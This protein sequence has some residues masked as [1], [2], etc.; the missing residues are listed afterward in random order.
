M[1]ASGIHPYLRRFILCVVKPNTNTSTWLLLYNAP[2]I[3]QTV[4]ALFALELGLILPTQP[5]VRVH[6]RKNRLY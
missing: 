6:W 4:K 3:I 1:P 5:P 2:S